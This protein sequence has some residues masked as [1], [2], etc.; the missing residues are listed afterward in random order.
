MCL[1]QPE[2]SPCTSGTEAPAGHLHPS[3]LHSELCSHSWGLPWLHHGCPHGWAAVVTVQETKE[4]WQPPCSAPVPAL[5]K[6][7]TARD[8]TA[9]WHMRFPSPQERASDTCHLLFWNLLRAEA[10]LDLLPHLKG[11]RSSLPPLHRA[12]YLLCTWW[13][14]GGTGALFMLSAVT[15]LQPSPSGKF[16]PLTLKA[17]LYFSIL[18]FN[19]ELSFLALQGLWKDLSIL[20]HYLQQLFPL[21]PHC[22]LTRVPSLRHHQAAI[23]AVAALPWHPLSLC[24]PPLFTRCTP[25]EMCPSC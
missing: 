18:P 19:M 17:Y 20:P 21:V 2:P 9:G 8:S 5:G 22:S 24:Q 7:Q 3:P 15:N 4:L 12:F 25:R 11:G 10:L 6:R 14:T 13:I 16:P 1:H 23:L